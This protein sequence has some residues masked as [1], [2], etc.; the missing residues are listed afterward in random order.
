MALRNRAT[1][2]VLTFR[3]CAREMRHGRMALIGFKTEG[4]IQSRMDGMCSVHETT[5]CIETYL[6]ASRVASWSVLY[7]W[8]W[9]SRRRAGGGH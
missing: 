6:S 3:A 8:S 5:A 2:D 7:F 4:M 1:G 9:R